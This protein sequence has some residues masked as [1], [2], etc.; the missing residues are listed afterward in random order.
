MDECALHKPPDL[1]CEGRAHLRMTWVKVDDVGRTDVVSC[2]TKR[3]EQL[4]IHTEILESRD[5]ASIVICDYHHRADEAKSGSVAVP[6][7]EVIKSEVFRR[8]CPISGQ[9]LWLTDAD[10][11]GAIQD[12]LYYAVFFDIAPHHVESFKQGLVEEC[13]A[14]ERFEPKTVRFHL[15]QSEIDPSRWLVLEAFSEPSGL[16]TSRN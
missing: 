1:D 6:K 12:A 4:G 3:R 10:F 7:V 15:F 2:F 5:D 8:V 9:R 16:F 13:A 11:V 14:I